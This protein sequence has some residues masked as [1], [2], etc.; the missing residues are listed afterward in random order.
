MGNTG[1][2]EA[3]LCVKV[4]RVAQPN[5]LKDCF[6]PVTKWAAPLTSS[7]PNTK[8]NHASVMSRYFGQYKS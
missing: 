4:V 2:Y 6:S 8:N 3:M 7:Y 1:T 5:I